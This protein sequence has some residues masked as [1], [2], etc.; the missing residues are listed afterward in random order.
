MKKLLLVLAL[1]AV[2]L[3]PLAA[4]SA[5]VFDLSIGLNASF[6]DGTLEA[7]KEFA[8]SGFDDWRFGLEMRTKLLFF[9]LDS[10][11]KIGM[12][13]NNGLTFSGLM[14]AGL[15]EDLFDTARIGVC[16]GPVIDYVLEDGESSLVID[17]NHVQSESFMDALTKSRFNLRATLDF[18][19]GP[20]IRLGVVW[21]VP[22]QY[23]I[24]EHDM[25]KLLPTG[26]DW[27]R[28][29]IALAIHMSLV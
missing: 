9:E 12:T 13:E 28:T 29:Q 25:N 15:S 26:E 19:L 2:L 21:T 6:R 17:G 3:A 24:E 22:T 23:T 7:F 14:V 10:A 8:D 16:F 27:T 5:G 1:S 20:V 18:F 4:Y 11:G